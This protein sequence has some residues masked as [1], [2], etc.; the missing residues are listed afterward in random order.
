MN[1]SSQSA[2]V[3]R[4]F[5]AARAEQPLLIGLVVGM[6]QEHGDELQRVALLPRRAARL[7]IHQIE[8]RPRPTGLRVRPHVASRHLPLDRRELEPHTDRLR[9]GCRRLPAASGSR[10]RSHEPGRCASAPKPSAQSRRVAATPAYTSPLSRPYFTFTTSPGVKRAGELRRASTQFVC[11]V[12]APNRRVRRE[13]VAPGRSRRDIDSPRIS[14]AFHTR[15]RRIAAARAAG[16]RERF[17]RSA[18][19]EM[20]ASRREGT[21]QPG[22]AQLCGPTHGNAEQQERD[23]IIG[24]PPAP[25]SWCDAM[26]LVHRSS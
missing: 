14:V 10:G 18:H 22:H 4:L 19:T 20:G 16:V 23:Q 17:V 2:E 5:C 26:T 24:S 9:G 21:N 25:S 15:A 11:A 12:V 8:L 13:A 7:G 3:L 6:L 1:G